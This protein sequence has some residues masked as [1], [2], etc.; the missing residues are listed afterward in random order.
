MK[1]IGS[2]SLKSSKTGQHLKVETF[3]I[4]A[5]PE[6]GFQCGLLGEKVVNSK[7]IADS[8]SHVWTSFLNIERKFGKPVGEQVLE[9]Q[10]G[11]KIFRKG[12]TN[13]SL[14]E[15]LLTE[16]RSL[17]RQGDGRGKKL[18]IEQSS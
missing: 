16:I 11:R 3:P 2:I 13:R 4:L 6:V 9:V 14:Q 10:I 15:A 12:T 18:L 5:E 1:K 7:A 8:V 17:S